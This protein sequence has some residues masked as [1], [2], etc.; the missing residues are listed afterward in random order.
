[1]CVHPLSLTGSHCRSHK[2]KSRSECVALAFAQTHT[3][4]SE[5]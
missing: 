2:K 1:M 4:G 5:H 3:C